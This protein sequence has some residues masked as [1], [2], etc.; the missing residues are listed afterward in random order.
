MKEPQ[1]GLEQ[2]LK[3]PEQ[4]LKDGWHGMGGSVSIPLTNEA[5]DFL[6]AQREYQHLGSIC[7]KDERAIALHQKAE[8]LLGKDYVGV[9]IT[10]TA[11]EAGHFPSFGSNNY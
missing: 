8:N 5:H 1:K 11:V 3:P 2:H 7:S 4:I 6:F 9:R 10:D